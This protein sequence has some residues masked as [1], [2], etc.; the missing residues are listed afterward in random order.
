M[1]KPKSKYKW[2]KAWAED[3]RVIRVERRADGKILGICPR[4]DVEGTWAWEAVIIANDGDQMVLG[5]YSHWTF[6]KRA[7]IECLENRERLGA[8]LIMP[9]GVLAQIAAE[10]ET[11]AESLRS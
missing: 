8:D 4:S 2:L 3:G 6:A 11:N 1:S 10:D 5:Q 9:P 7:V